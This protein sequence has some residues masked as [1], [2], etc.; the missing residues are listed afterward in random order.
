M[1]Y[2]KSFERQQI[3]EGK[4]RPMNPGQLNYLITQLLIEYCDN[5][6]LKYQIINDCIGALECAKLEFVRRVVNDYEAK[7]VYDN[8]D[9]YNSMEIK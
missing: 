2:I 1:P 6:G 5:N 8:G 7:K 4:L 3:A 9:C